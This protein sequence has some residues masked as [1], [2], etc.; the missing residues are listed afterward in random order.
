[1]LVV[2]GGLCLSHSALQLA[3]GPQ[4]KE[5]ATGLVQRRERGF[6]LFSPAT[7]ALLSFRFVAPL[8]AD[9]A[10]SQQGNNLRLKCPCV[11]ALGRMDS[12]GATSDIAPSMEARAAWLK[13]QTK[14]Q[15]NL[16]TPHQPG[17]LFTRL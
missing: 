1:M 17:L 6:C 3:S 8:A 15:L 9:R 7:E 14:K 5:N 16:C 10:L 11:P 2:E 4:G 13:A 12:E